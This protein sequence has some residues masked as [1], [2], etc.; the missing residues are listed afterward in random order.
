[1]R[2][3]TC[4]KD[5]IR[6]S[7]FHSRSDR[8]TS[9]VLLINTTGAQP[10]GWRQPGSSEQIKSPL[11]K[12]AV[13]DQRRRQLSHTGR[14]WELRKEHMEIVCN[15]NPTNETGGEEHRIRQIPRGGSRRTVRLY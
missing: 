1:M 10:Y 7:E 9:P 5:L 11:E 2:G 12:G 14:Q 4:V 8:Q 15:W 3:K 6:I 13:V